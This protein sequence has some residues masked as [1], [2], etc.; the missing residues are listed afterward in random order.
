MGGRAATRCVAL[1]VSLALA[2]VTG[3]TSAFA[4]P[5]EGEGAAEATSEAVMD[6]AAPVDAAPG[7]GQD[8]I[9][10][11]RQLADN[12]RQLFRDGSFRAAIEA[13]EKAYELA[14][15]PNLLFNIALSYE[16]LE[17]WE[18][19]LEAL[20][21]YR[22]YAVPDER[23]ALET[24]RRQLQDRLA[25]E[26]EAQ[27]P[28]PAPPPAPQDPGGPEGPEPEARP[29]PLINGVGYTLGG[30]AVVSLGVGITLGSIALSQ[31]NG[32]GEDCATVDGE[33]L[34]NEDGGE[35]RAQA[36]GLAIGADVSFAVSAVAAT[37]FLISLAVQAGKRKKARS[38][39]VTPTAGRTGAG[40]VL[41][42]RF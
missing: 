3:I 20:D 13:F 2:S 22:A 39:N 4:A 1:G 38:V 28:D 26:R 34:C 19:A 12:G 18:M 6:D 23:E 35:S 5:P 33:Q 30:V 11:A 37:G 15:D 7:E 29:I 14:A 31:I 36:R 21:R 25:S 17:E 24:R 40:L 9:A 41:S 32:G 10:R 16:R 8:D 27:D 42:G